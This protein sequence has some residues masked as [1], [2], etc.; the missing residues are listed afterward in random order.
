[1]G[2]ERCSGETT[3]ISDTASYVDSNLSMPGHE[4]EL[5]VDTIQPKTHP[6]QAWCLKTPSQSVSVL[7][8]FPK[9]TAQN[10]LMSKGG[11]M[12]W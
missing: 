7:V 10:F 5:C 2:M 1:M 12:L 3:F 9:L 8:S 4:A 11:M 6:R